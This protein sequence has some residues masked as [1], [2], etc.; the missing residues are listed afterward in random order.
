MIR[1]ELNRTNEM[2]L[3]AAP[4]EVAA[5]YGLAQG[6]VTFRKVWIELDCCRGGFVC[7]RGTFHVRHYT[8]DTEPVVIAGH[9]RMGQCVFR[10]E[11][12]RLLV[13][14][15]GSRESVFSK[16]IPVKTSAQICF[17]RLWIVGAALG[18]PQ[19][20]VHR[21]MRHDRFGDVR[22]NRV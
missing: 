17:V 21:Q 12:D 10:I 15:D 6:S 13:T 20:L 2:M 11:R 9:A 3:G 22:R 16:R 4:R 7:C 14:N 18:E 8:E 1:I 5:E 19:S